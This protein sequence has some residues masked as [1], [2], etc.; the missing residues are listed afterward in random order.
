MVHFSVAEI[1]GELTCQPPACPH[2][3]R[4]PRADSSVQPKS[5]QH[6]LKERKLRLR[7]HRSPCCLCTEYPHCLVLRGTPAC[8]SSH[9][10][11]LHTLTVWFPTVFLNDLVDLLV[12]V[13]VLPGYLERR[14]QRGS[15]V[16]EHSSVSLRIQDQPSRRV[17]KF[18][19]NHE[20]SPTHPPHVPSPSDV[21][22]MLGGFLQHS[23]C[24]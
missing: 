23:L 8:T 22:L 5:K 19:N 6:V 16:W 11:N 10:L 14:V 21:I 9:H 7:K 24:P 2:R 17:Y 15:V 12:Q 18:C 13:F 3:I 4:N 20:P 1:S